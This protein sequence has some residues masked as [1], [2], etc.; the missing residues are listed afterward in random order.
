M[1]ELEKTAEWI[2]K[3]YTSAEKI[4]EVGVGRVTRVLEELSRKMPETELI[5]TDIRE[6]TVPDGVKFV[7][8]DIM[9]P[10][11]EVYES[12]ALVYSMRPPAEFYP[13]LSKIGEKTGSDL[14][15]NPVSSEESPLWGNPI[16]YSG[17]FFYVKKYSQKKAG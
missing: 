7:R 10:K 8:D 9:D 5:A 1:K 4:V 14:M 15:V 6:V 13:L 16:N 11:M 12:A 3:N 2:S 17:V